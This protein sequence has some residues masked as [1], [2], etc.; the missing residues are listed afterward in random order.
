MKTSMKVYHVV[1]ALLILAGVYSMI[2]IQATASSGNVSNVR[3]A[4]IGSIAL[5]AT[6]LAGIQATCW[7]LGIGGE[8]K[9]DN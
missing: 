5:T 9:R 2:W 3:G 1:S 6:I 8:V 4:L 7:I